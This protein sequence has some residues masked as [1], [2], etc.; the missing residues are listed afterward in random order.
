MK[1]V[2]S[3]KAAGR[4]EQALIALTPFVAQ[5]AGLSTEATPAFTNAWA[6]LQRA[7][8]PSPLARAALDVFGLEPDDLRNRKRLAA[9]LAE[10][11]QDTELSELQTLLSRLPNDPPPNVTFNNSGLNSGQQVGANSGN[12]IQA[13]VVRRGVA[14]QLLGDAAGTTADWQRAWEL[15][16]TETQNAHWHSK[17]ARLAIFH[18]DV[19]AAQ[20]HYTQ[21]LPL[22]ATNVSD[23]RDHDR[24]LARLARLFPEHSE[25]AALNA[26]FAEQ[27][28]A[29]K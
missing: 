1:G 6:I 4:I 23:L 17:A 12:I 19:E 27:A 13:N 25:I 3:M 15:L 5:A 24:H 22:V 16:Q 10:L 7:A 11:L 9:V 28:K 26:W 14:K 8:Q 20:A 18:G 21:M 2:A 29:R